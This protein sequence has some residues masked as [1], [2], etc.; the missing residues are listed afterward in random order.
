MSKAQADWL[1]L[2]TDG[3]Q[4]FAPGSSEYIQL[5]QPEVV[6]GAIRE[7]YEAVLRSR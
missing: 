3:K 5:D 1:E 6:V 2:T 4:L 7:V